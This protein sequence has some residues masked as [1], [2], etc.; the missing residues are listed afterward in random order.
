MTATPEVLA[1]SPFDTTRADRLMEE[2]GIDILLANSKHNTRYLLG[3]HSFFFFAHMDAFGHSRYLP[4]VLY[5]RGRTADAAYIG[6]AMEAWDHA[7]RPFWTP[8][9]IAAS[10]G[11]KDAAALAVEHIKKIGMSRARIGIEPAFLPVDAYQVL[12]DGLGEAKIVD[13]TGVLERLRAIKSDQELVKLRKASEL[14]T[15]SMLAT[16]AWAREGTSKAEVIEHLRQEETRR[17]LNFD[18]CLLTFGTDR[19][20]ASSDQRL[21]PGDPMSIDSG[22]SLDGYIG[23]LC[24]MG[25]LGEPDTELEDLLSEIDAVQQAVFSNVRGGAIAGD[26]LAKGNA[27]LKAGPSAACTDLV[28]HGMGLIS[29]EVPFVMSNRMY[30]GVD[31]QRPFE[32]GMVLSVETTMGHPRRGFIKLEDTF[33]VTKD[34]CEMFG[35]RGRG[36]NRAGTDRHS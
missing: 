33:A 24:R 31:A 25:V 5:R 32:P 26:A 15:D 9:F 20:R 21:A 19:N 18:Y 27:V 35:D 16:F 7:L 11:S 13:A 28:I 17:G 3:G 29:H 4:L 30:E 14:I 10:W 34:G 12:I 2:A 6:G 1:H 8:T 23:D 36:W 22:G